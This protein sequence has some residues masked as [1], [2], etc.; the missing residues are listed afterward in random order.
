[1]QAPRLVQILLLHPDK[2]PL[3][4]EDRLRVGGYQLAQPLDARE[5]IWLA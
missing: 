4:L 3:V 2:R 5:Q 1:M